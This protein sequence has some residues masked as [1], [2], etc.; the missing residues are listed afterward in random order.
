LAVIKDRQRHNDS[1]RGGTLI[2]FTVVASAFFTM[3]LAI[4]AGSNLYFTHNALV[5][6]TR[7]GARF[8]ATQ[9]ANSPVGAP[10]TTAAGTCDSTGPNL[11]SIK[12]YAIYGNTA[13]TG[14]NPL[15]LQPANICVQ[16]SATSSAIGQV[17]FGVGTG[18]VTVSIQNYTFYYI[19]PGINRQITMPAYKTTVAG[20]SA[21]TCAVLNA[22]N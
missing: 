2:E 19:V 7:R 16:Y 13:G 11:A 14:S 12:N 1:E 8:A 6:A 21:G 9:P 15:S 20:E 5:E 22:C 10:R 17:G 18:A 4:C 3:L